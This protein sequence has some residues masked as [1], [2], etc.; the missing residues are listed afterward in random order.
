MITNTLRKFSKF[1]LALLVGLGLATGPNL[2]PAAVASSCLS[3]ADQFAM[4][5]SNF[6]SL[7]MERC[8]QSL[9]LTA[10]S[11]K[12]SSL[13]NLAASLYGV[14]FKTEAFRK[15]MEYDSCRETKPAQTQPGRPAPVASP[16]STKSV[17]VPA[18]PTKPKASAPEQCPN[19]PLPK[20][21]LARL[22]YSK[23]P[24]LEVLASEDLKT[25][26]VARDE[27]L[28][29][30]LR[31]L[32]PKSRPIE[33]TFSFRTKDQGGTWSRWSEPITDVYPSNPTPTNVIS[34]VNNSYNHRG[35]G[36]AISESESI[37]V[38]FA[39]FNGCGLSKVFEVTKPIGTPIW[40][41]KLGNPT[42]ISCWVSGR[43]DTPV[44]TF[45]PD[46]RS[47]NHSSVY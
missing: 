33:F 13:I 36:L 5:K 30:L 4:S 27:S 26:L 40:N 39:F 38:R 14:D 11:A 44:L 16:K 42:W 31:S 18:V 24:G 2:S 43:Q 19:T 3:K 22:L 20:T 12:C 47:H 28:V 34:F 7:A 46:C 45:K 8:Y 25:R 21:N 32:D 35:L 23:D 6:D 37:R 10:T 1:S 29:F 15:V 17:V 41:P 9:G